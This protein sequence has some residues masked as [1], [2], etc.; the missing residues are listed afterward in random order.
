MEH[1][2][3]NI[4]I[5]GCANIAVRS[6]IPA[7]QELGDN[8]VISGIASRSIKK[9][10]DCAKRFETKAYY[11]Y[12]L[13][14][15]DS[16]IDAV[17]IPLPNSLHY[18]YVKKAILQNKHVL[19][20]KS[21]ACDFDQVKHLNELAKKSGVALVENF[22]FRFHPQLEI[23]KNLISQSIIGEIRSI[24]SSFG[25]PP[26]PDTDN[27]RYKR[28]LCGGALLDA[29]AYPIKISQILLGDTISVKA[30]NLHYDEDLNVD[31][32]GGAYLQQN[33]GSLFSEIAFGFDNFYQCNVEIWGS[34]GKISAERIFT[35]PPGYVAE[36]NVQT[37]NGMDV[38]KVEYANHFKNM[39][40]YFIG[41]VKGN[42]NEE[43]FKNINQARLI[44]ELR[45]KAIK[46]GS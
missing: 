29:G 8:Y 17:Y 28:E 38:I 3:I 31:I 9:A 32:W 1:Q 16:N 30:A 43:Y 21:L 42:N 4:G 27:I 41:C 45:N 22:Q 40:L 2:K 15:E 18:D 24:R 5:L 7:I 13:L 46:Q 37:N 34:K 6:V 39:L 12:D 33:E 44:D 36:V 10:N 23:I 25:F 20:E 14:L 19:V 11:S 26:F 35:A